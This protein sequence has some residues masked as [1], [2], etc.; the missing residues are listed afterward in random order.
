MNKKQGCS[1][2]L[3]VREM[4]FKITARH[5]YKSSRMA[6]IKQIKTSDNTKCYK[7]CKVIETHSLMVV[8]Q[9][10]MTILE[11]NVT[12]SYKVTHVCNI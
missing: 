12:V 4:Q 6:E 5:N 11:N 9:N 2:S 3:V 7:K 8:M 1:K 10:D